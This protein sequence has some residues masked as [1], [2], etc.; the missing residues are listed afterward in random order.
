MTFEAVFAED[1]NNNEI[2]DA[3][4]EKYKV[5]F[6]AGDNGTLEG[7]LEFKDLLKD[8]TFAD[9]N[10]IVPTP[11]ANKHYQFAKWDVTPSESTTV[12]GDMKFTA[13]FEAVEYT[14]TFV[15]ENGK[16]VDEVT[17]TIENT[18]VTEP[19]VPTKAGYSG[20]WEK[21]DITDGGNV[22]V[23][24]VYTAD[25]DTEYT[26]EY[27][28]EKLD[29]TFAVESETLSAETDTTVNA[30]VKE[31]E[32]FTHA[33]TNTNNV[34]SGNVA[35]DG[36]LVLK[37]YYTRNSYKI[38]YVVDKETV[39]VETYKY[40]ASV[41]PIDDPTK[42]GYTFSGWDNIVPT[43]M[44]ANDV[45]LSG[46]FTAKGDTKYVVEYY[47][48]KLDGTYE[49]ETENKTAA[50]DSTVEVLPKEIIGFTYDSANNNNLLTGTVA[51]DGSLVLKVYYTRNSYKL[52]Y[53]VDKETVKEETYKYEEN[54]TA[55]AT[56]EKT[57]Y[58]FSGWDKTVP[59]TM[60]AEDVTVSGSFTANKDTKYTVEYYKENLDGTFA[61]ESET[62]EAETDTTVNAE[63]KEFTGFTHAATNTENVLEGAVAG[64]GSLV[65][66][67]YYTRNS[68][69]LTYV[70][71]KE[72]VKEETYKYE[73]NVTAIATPEKT[74][75][76][77]SGWDKTVPTTMPA[78]DVTVSGSFTAN[79][80]TKY[81]IEYYTENT[82]GTFSVNSNETKT[83]TTGTTVSAT[84]KEI[85]GFAY[86]SSN[87]N[88]VLSGTVA[89]DGS[90]V[91]KLYYNKIKAPNVSVTVESTI[92]R[93]GE[94]VT[95]GIVEYGDVLNYTVTIKNTG[96]ADGSVL[97]K[98]I[99]TGKLEDITVADEYKAL[100]ETSGLTIVVK[101]NETI[102][103]TFSGTVKTGV[104]EKVKNDIS[105]SV[106]GGETTTITGTE[107]DTQKTI[108]FV[109]KTEI[110]QGTNIV[111]VLDESAS[112]DGDKF[113]TAKDA[114]NSFI[115]Q[116]FPSANNNSNGSTVAVVTFGTETICTNSSGICIITG[117]KTQAYAN[118]IGVTAT[119]YNSA[120][121]LKNSI[122]GLSN[123][124]Y[125]SGTPYYIGL[126]NAYNILY[127]ESNGLYKNGNKNVVIFL[128]DGAPDDN[129][130]ETQR[131]TYINNL[132]SKGTDIYAIGFD[133]T[134]GSDAHTT[135]GTVANKGV[136][137]AGTD[138]LTK[139]FSTIHSSIADNNTSKQTSQGVAEIADTIVVDE[140]HP[141]NIK[142]NGVDNK[143]YSVDEVLATG[144]LTYTSE[145]GYEVDATKF[146]AGDVIEVIYFAEVTNTQALTRSAVAYS[147]G[148]LVSR[149]RV[150]ETPAPTT[151]EEIVEEATKE[152]IVEESTKEEVT[153]EPAK[154][155]V[156]EPT[157]EVVEEP[158]E[159][160]VEE[161]TEEVV[162]EST[163]EEIVEEP[164]KEEVV[165]EP[166]KEEVVED[167]TKEEIVEDTTKEE[168][169]GE[170]A[171][172]EIV[173]ESTKEEV[174]E[175]SA[176]ENEKE[177]E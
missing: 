18:K 149:A 44:P 27:Y 26:V 156:E 112:M 108:S 119:D 36:S 113:A 147:Y 135:L 136:F 70:V 76:T 152:E 55:I 22:T 57:G 103:I 164:T 82:D 127:N 50:T 69:K 73:E 173:E 144:Y 94:A 12:T 15:D 29:G 7:T 37:V 49:V 47:K 23:K 128:S 85:A 54:V 175:E 59:T 138:D 66:K 60:P 90:L 65:L 89:G 167:T 107:Y 102:T 95:G 32:G 67:V 118:V 41:N 155:V 122:S 6:V 68:Y 165:E 159:E 116:V 97:L 125:N 91:L 11:K 19:V 56:P 74:G 14:V 171:K 86:D 24:P 80:N 96:D 64:D 33:S 137:I 104:N 111:I 145:E 174:V 38:T 176:E 42:V 78:E 139:I 133:I 129:D 169:V 25:K 142:V 10:I 72:T 28:K 98:D 61:K 161:P 166:T 4:E 158:T 117:W 45:T 43:T 105:Y 177:T 21:Y 83:A 63:I 93:D 114:T 115:S 52:T 35:G 109:E 162:E 31:F 8:L 106:N 51:G 81:T 157:E 9:Q 150:Q 20:V 131:N 172:E 110:I 130:D 30:E 120:T 53:V 148:S 146:A 17:Y 100:F 2:P 13:S 77:F 126:Q 40:E 140:S 48:E 34:L 84:A 39:K 168:I 1:K 101:P 121:S 134:S 160:V 71:D 141:I 124:I 143:Y 75:Y 87:T 170:P 88:N 132:K 62:K 79:T 5:E 92:T 151:T 123:D 46:N 163:K 58:T 153:E 3:N 16:T 154:E 99:V